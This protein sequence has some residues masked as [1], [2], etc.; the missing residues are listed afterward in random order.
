MLFFGQKMLHDHI[1]SLSFDTNDI[2]SSLQHVRDDF[3]GDLVPKVNGVVHCV[4]N[5][6]VFQS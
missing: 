4:K 1:V 2:F 6:N 5:N 3:Y